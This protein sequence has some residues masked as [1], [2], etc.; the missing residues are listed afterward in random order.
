MGLLSSRRS[1]DK[2]ATFLHRYDNILCFVCFVVGIT[3]FLLL[4]YSDLNARTYFSENALL[5]GLVEPE[6]HHGHQTADYYR[7]LKDEVKKRKSSDDLRNRIPASWIMK[8]F[9]EIGLDTYI[10]NFTFRY[11]HNMHKDYYGRNIYGILR[12]PRTAGTEAVILSAPFRSE[13]S[14]ENTLA[15]IALMLA[16]A[17]AFREHTY[18]AKDVIFLIAE[19]DLIGMQ[20]WLSA[21][22]HT[23]SEYIVPDE[24]LS[25][26]GSIQ[27]A[28]NLEIATDKISHVGLNIEGLNGQLPNLDLVNT[29]TRLCKREAIT[30]TLHK[31]SDYHSLESLNGFLYSLKTM[32]LLMTQ[33]ASGSPTGNHGLFH[34]YSIEAVTLTGI[35]AKGTKNLLGFREVGRVVEGVFR[36]L[37]NLLERF[38]QSF[39]FYILPSAER[40]VSIGV[41][42]PPFGILALP[43]V[44]KAL[45][46]WLCC[47][48]V[49]HES[50]VED[51]TLN[52]EQEQAGNDAAVSQHQTKQ[53][54]S[55]LA[56]KN[57]FRSSLSQL[58]QCSGYILMSVLFGAAAYYGGY[59]FIVISQEMNVSASSGLTL[60]IVLLHVVV[61]VFPFLPFWKYL[62]CHEPV[63]SKC[64]EVEGNI[65][66]DMHILKSVALL[67]FSVLLGTTAVVNISLGFFIGVISIPV[68]VCGESKKYRFLKIVKGLALLLIS[69][70]A[71]CCMAATVHMLVTQKSTSSSLSADT[72]FKHVK[73]TVLLSLIQ[74]NFFDNWTYGLVSFAYFPCWTLFW[75]VSCC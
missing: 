32:L 17:K 34:R 1:Y 65:H 52:T 16:L 25:K 50:R 66:A 33:L 69:P 74:L 73:N 10:Q 23:Y 64:D 48:V 71:V 44:I 11:P 67:A 43:I 37:N 19:D 53:S 30:P 54:L 28:L 38:H 70:I 26:S 7:L 27:A 41:Y 21:Y 5:P 3:W 57:D 9:V 47:H 2:I 58:Y 14:E 24:L 22:H 60:G 42:M 75:F 56:E 59:V 63:T 29:V 72:V 46:L 35:K 4:A 61:V 13:P 62:A 6:F 18:W 8:K 68:L 51:D 40:Y 45:S 39:F 20:A 31:R 36:S 55:P 15:G 49:V 12:A